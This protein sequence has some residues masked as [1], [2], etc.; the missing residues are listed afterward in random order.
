GVQV[1][2]QA[3]IHNEPAIK[4]SSKNGQQV[5]YVT[6]GSYQP[7]ELDTTGQGG[8]STLRFTVYQELTG[9]QATAAQLSLTAEHPNAKVDHS[10]AD[11]QAAENRLFPNG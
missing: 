1:D 10:T 4:I 3:S 5:Y 9:A 8:S 7:I 6:P 2:T 11:Y